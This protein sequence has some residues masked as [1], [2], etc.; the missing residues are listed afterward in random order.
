MKSGKIS[1]FFAVI[2]AMSGVSHADTADLNTVLQ[3][4]YRACVDIDENLHDLKVLAGVN[5]AVTA[6]GTASGVGASATGFAKA[7]KDASIE[8]N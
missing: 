8:R 3:N 5:T 7:S 2:F 4:T 1:V 6:V